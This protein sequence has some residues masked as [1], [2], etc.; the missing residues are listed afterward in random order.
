MKN[1]FL[2]KK[3]KNLFLKEIIKHKYPYCWR[4]KTILIFRTTKQWFFNINNKKLKNKIIKLSNNLIKWNPKNGAIKIKNMIKNRLD[5][6]ISRQRVWG[7]PIILLLDKNN[8]IHPKT[9][10]ILDKA[11]ILTK[12]NGADFWYKDNIFKLFDINKKKYKQVIDVLDVWF[13][14][15]VVYDYISKT[16]NI[17]L[18]IDLCIEGNDQYRGWF[19]VSIINSISNYKFIPYKNILTHGFILDADGKKMSKSLN[20]II[21]PNYIIK[22]HGAEIFRLWTSSVNYKFD[23]NFS[24]ETI[25]RICEAYR[26]IRNTFRFMLS[27]TEQIKLN[28]K[29]YFF[30]T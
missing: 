3:S 26:K 14:S 17:K 20:N 4:H 18:P 15:S 22:K 30:K 1:N 12:N 13:D 16:E 21:S 27:N 10:N 24:E 28:S 9:I 19:Q 29:H 23:V 25:K 6:C 8:K 11:S 5:W 7:V 2:L